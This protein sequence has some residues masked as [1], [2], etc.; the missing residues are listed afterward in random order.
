MAP[1]R[2]GWCAAQRQDA[3]HDLVQNSN[4]LRHCA[5]E[6][7][8]GLSEQLRKPAAMGCVKLLE[9]Q[10]RLTS[11]PCASR[12]VCTTA[13]VGLRQQRQMLLLLD[14]IAAS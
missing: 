11:R 2:D 3:A 9:I 13:I 10:G 8:G 1:A 6:G 14:P 7:E 12:R 4:G 5:I